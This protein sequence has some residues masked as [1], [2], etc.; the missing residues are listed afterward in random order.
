M[1]PQIAAGVVEMYASLHSGAFL[2]DY[3]RNR[4]KVLGKVKLED[5]AK[6]FA[7][8]FQKD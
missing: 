7:A 2:E 4:P 5:F 6:E 8:A 3:F 1:N